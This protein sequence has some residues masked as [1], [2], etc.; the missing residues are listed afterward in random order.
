MPLLVVLFIGIFIR[1]ILVGNSGFIADIAFWKSWSLAAIDKGIVA[2]T[3]I[4]NIN[5]PP[6]F[7]YV[8]W[9]MGKIYSL[10][11]DPHNFNDFWRDNNFGFLLASKSIAIISDIAIAVLIYWFFKQKN[12]L[13]TLG[14][15]IPDGIKLKI[16]SAPSPIRNLITGIRNFL[17]GNLP[18]V[19]AAVFFLNPVVIL[20]SALWGQVESFG[21]LFTLIAITFLFHKKPLAASILFVIGTQMKLQN[22]IY[23]PLFY[24]FIWRTY[25][26]RTLIKSLAVAAVTFF[27]LYIPFIFANDMGKVLDLLTVN[28]D[29]FPYLSLNAHNIWWVVSGAQ[30]MSVNDKITILG[31][32]NAKTIGLLLFS[33][34]YLLNM[35]LLYKKP[36]NRN[37]LLTLAVAIFGFFL[38]TTES[39]ERY[40]YPVIVLL[41]FLYPFLNPKELIQ[42]KFPWYF[43]ML[44]AFLTVSIFLN[45][46]TGLILNYPE[47]GWNLLTLVT[48]YNPT[49][50]IVN[51]FFLTALFFF[52]LPY[53]FNQ[54]SLVWGISCAGLLCIALTG[55]NVSYIFGTKIPLTKFKPIVI[56]QDYGL[57][58][59]NRSVNSF[60]GW[61]SWGRLSSDY[62]YYRKG[63]GTHANSRLVFD[64]NRMFK[65]FSTDYGIDVNAS[66][67]ASVVFKIIGD[68]K[69]LFVSD[70]IGRFDFPHH[71]EV[72]ITN[73]K[74]LELVVTDAGDGINSD[75]ADWDNPMLIK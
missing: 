54:I 69:E 34:V 48:R 59:T 29:Y 63:F 62:F 73:V 51:S 28:G 58:Q 75:H 23:I 43:W 64:V 3:H 10:F 27:I 11:G 20:D 1:L 4:T 56:K 61:K 44:Y 32:I 26:L 53:V 6:A 16:V 72:D 42:K 15:T 60:Q 14:A 5:Y 39:H 24:L 17:S 19:L 12:L 40:S 41:L 8:L 31:I 74:K 45:I 33:G 71:I 7:T 47:N 25:D 52:L 67:A 46:H 2:T 65:K 68:G 66:T 38:F 30:G 50:S 55:L 49:I 18:L 22:I 57:L 35:I 13:K 21:F 9:V 70:R 36:T 37:F